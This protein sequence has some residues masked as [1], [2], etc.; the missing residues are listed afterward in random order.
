MFQHY[1]L[2]G[3]EIHLLVFNIYSTLE[4]HIQRLLIEQGGNASH[5]L[6]QRARSTELN[7]VRLLAVT[8]SSMGAARC[9]TGCD[10]YCN[11]LYCIFMSALF[12]LQKT[13]V[14]NPF[15]CRSTAFFASSQLCAQYTCNFTHKRFFSLYTSHPL[16][17][18]DSRGNP[19]GRCRFLSRAHSR[20]HSTY[21]E[22]AAFNDRPKFARKVRRGCESNGGV[23]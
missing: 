12:L 14:Q 7:L 17:G 23:T 15:L 11:T 18:L 10:K 4:T 8:L 19:G 1:A 2:E 5:R 16:S 13:F 22:D 21:P 20:L 9:C 3:R 6:A